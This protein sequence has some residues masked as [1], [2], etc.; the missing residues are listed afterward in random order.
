MLAKALL[1]LS[2]KSHV[3]PLSVVLILLSSSAMM[4]YQDKKVLAVTL[5]NDKLESLVFTISIR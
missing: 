2:S 4:F 3:A 1:S 5:A